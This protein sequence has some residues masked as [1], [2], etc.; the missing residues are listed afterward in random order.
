MLGLAIHVLEELVDIDGVVLGVGD[1]LGFAEDSSHSQDI[2]LKAA[3]DLVQT[4]N[5]SRVLRSGGLRQLIH[6][7]DRKIAIHEFVE[8]NSTWTDFILPRAVVG[9]KKADVGIQ[10][11]VQV[12]MEPLRVATVTDNALAIARLF[13]KS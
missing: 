1:D 11:Q 9:H 2:G 7:R 10:Q 3:A 13:V 5:V 6:W 12:A 4:G 8:Q